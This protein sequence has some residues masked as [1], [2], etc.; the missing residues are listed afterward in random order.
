MAM[1]SPRGKE[2]EARLTTARRRT[3]AAWKTW[4]KSPSEIRGVNSNKVRKITGARALFP[5]RKL[6]G[7]NIIP[8]NSFMRNCCSTMDHNNWTDEH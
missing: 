2:L 7:A 8:A 1:F 4:K 5:L 6:L 3:K